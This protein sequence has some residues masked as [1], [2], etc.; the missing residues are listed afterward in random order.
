MTNYV[1]LG[2]LVCDL[3]KAFSPPERLT[4][5]EAAEKYVV[6]H[7]APAFVG[8]YKN[9]LAP[10][11]IE[12]MNMTESRLFKVVAFGGPAQSAKTQALIQNTLA[13]VVK[14]NP[15]D[16]ILYEKS[17]AAARDF[18]KRRLDRMH[19][20]SPQVG[21]ELSPGQHSDNTFD[22][23]Y[24]S[25]MMFT[26][27]WPSINEMSGR[28]IP[29][30]MLTDYD[31]MPEDIDGEGAPFD[32]ARKRTT[33]FGTFA[34]TI[35][36]SS[37]GYEVLDPKWSPSPGSH[38][39]PPCQGI[40]SI[41]NHGDRRL[42][43][44]KCP[45]A[46]CR[47]WFEP[48]FKLLQ[49][50]QRAN[51]DAAADSVMMRCPHCAVLFSHYLKHDL[52]LAG[53]WIPEG[54]WIDEHDVLHGDAVKSDIAS[55]WLKGPAATFV[56]W[57][58]LVIKFLQAEE[59]YAKTGSQEKLKTTVNTDQGEPYLPRGS[60]EMRMAEDL[61][62]MAQNLPE[63]KVPKHVRALVASIDVQKNRWEVQVHG[64]APGAPFSL[65]LIDRFPIQ[66]SKRIDESS[67]NPDQYLWVKPSAHLED[68]DLITEQVLDRTYELEDGT[69]E[70]S[71]S[72]TACDS[73]GK[74]GVTTMAYNYWRKLRKAG[75][76][77]NFFLVK[78]VGHPTAP[79]VSLEFPD[80]QR[81]DRLASVR[82][83]IPLLEINSNQVKDALEGMLLRN[84][85]AIGT[86]AFPD[87]LEKW[88]YEELTVETRIN[89]KWENKLGRRNESWD[90]FCYCIAVCIHKKVENINWSTPPTWLLPWA[91]NP[92]VFLRPVEGQVATPKKSSY[93][94]LAQL[95]SALG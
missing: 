85:S 21:M 71:V 86:I 19:R 37:P 16:V 60:E 88:F 32:L 87:W 15:K 35:V 24:R 95:G 54:Q 76:S 53:R 23:I 33:T 40:L 4:V 22:K 43:F 31:R 79:R 25:G 51:I 48:T 84:E 57:K 80:A 93:G 14:S 42:W 90:L 3:A 63:K 12:P 78:G 10:Y 45:D 30:V 72:F 92:N 91:E 55:F 41:Y 1:D 52:N 9:D 44:W 36:E 26:M 77:T 5:A 28:S 38:E 27:S 61:M 17:Q 75:R 6:L 68:W 62:D 82:G 8:P 66:H 47:K 20:H 13:Y 11:M 46:A 50:N 59:E 18:S 89:G 58:E 81:K 69:G 2:Q 73:G 67:P 94:R 74:D 56:T 70:M 39:A 49:W 65:V 7:N 64:V 83:D 29:L 34:M